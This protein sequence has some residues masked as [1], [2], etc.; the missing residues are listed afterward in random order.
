MAELLH[1]SYIRMEQKRKDFTTTVMLA[2]CTWDA[3]GIAQ[4]KSHPFQVTLDHSNL[5]PLK[6]LKVS[7]LHGSFT[8][9]IYVALC[10]VMYY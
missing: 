9:Y 3:F 7:Y 5:T 2:Y 1:G 8:M 4:I 10:H 6:S